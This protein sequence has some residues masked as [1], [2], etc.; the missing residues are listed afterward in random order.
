[1]KSFQEK[2]SLYLLPSNCGSKNSSKHVLNDIRQDAGLLY[3]V[4]ITILLFVL[5]TAENWANSRSDLETSCN[6]KKIVCRA[7]GKFGLWEI[8]K[9]FSVQRKIAFWKPALTCLKTGEILI[10]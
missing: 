3:S 4:R 6:F 1:M 5:S 10:K 7:A 2:V 8:S 9:F